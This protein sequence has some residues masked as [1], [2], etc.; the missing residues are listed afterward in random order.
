V[1][2][3]PGVNRPTIPLLQKW[4]KAQRNALSQWLYFFVEL[5]QTKIISLE[6]LSVCSFHT[7]TKTVT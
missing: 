5:A 4:K 2:D 3:F 1:A 6:H 7:L